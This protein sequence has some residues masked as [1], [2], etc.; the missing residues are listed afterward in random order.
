MIGKQGNPNTCRYSWEKGEITLCC[1]EEQVILEVLGF[2]L[3]IFQS[4]SLLDHRDPLTEP[5]QIPLQFNALD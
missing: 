2:E 4:K 5:R 3:L 1:R